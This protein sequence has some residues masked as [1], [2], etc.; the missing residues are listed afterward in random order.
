[1]YIINKYALNSE[2]KE[3]EVK[4]FWGMGQINKENILAIGSPAV[5]ERICTLGENNVLKLWSFKG[6]ERKIL[7]EEKLAFKATEIAVHPCGLLVAINF[8]TEIKLMS[9]LPSGIY[10]VMS[11]KTNYN[12]KGLR[13]SDCGNYLV[14]N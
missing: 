11:A 7:F 2:E 12:S 9:L 13:F 6:R 8:T 1:M 4:L 10:E 3:E 5:H 14:S